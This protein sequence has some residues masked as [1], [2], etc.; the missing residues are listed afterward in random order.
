MGRRIEWAATLLQRH[1]ETVDALLPNHELREVDVV[2]LHERQRSGQ[3]VHQD[4]SGDALRR[5]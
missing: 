4:E 5:T 3:R 2:T 1:R